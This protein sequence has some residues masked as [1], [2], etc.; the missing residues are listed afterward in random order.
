MLTLKD[1]HS[2]IHSLIHS[3]MIF[4]LPPLGQFCASP[5]D[6]ALNQTRSLPLQLWRKI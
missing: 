4:E 1:I 5:E 6:T 2:F 3:T